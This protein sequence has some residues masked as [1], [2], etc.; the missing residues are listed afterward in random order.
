MCLERD[1]W[2]PD[3]L[4]MSFTTYNVLF[5]A[6]VIAGVLGTFIEDAISRGHECVPHGIPTCTRLASIPTRTQHGVPSARC[7]TV[8]ADPQRA[9]LVLGRPGRVLHWPVGRTKV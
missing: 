3:L 7:S 1:T 5:G 6:C 9:A 8:P 4:S 2:E